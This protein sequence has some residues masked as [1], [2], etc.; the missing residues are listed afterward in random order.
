MLGKLALAEGAREVAASVL[1]E[2]DLD[3]EGAREPGFLEDLAL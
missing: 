2:L 3:D 1:L